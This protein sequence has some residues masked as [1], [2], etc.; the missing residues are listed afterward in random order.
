MSK[1]ILTPGTESVRPTGNGYAP[2]I[3]EGGPKAVTVA[4]DFTT[5]NEI[6]IDFTVIQQL[7]ALSFLQSVFVDNRVNPN[8]LVLTFDQTGQI[9]QI[10]ALSQGIYPVIATVSSKCVATTIAGANVICSLI[11]LNMPMPLTQWGP[12]TV[13]I[14]NV[15]AT[16]TPTAATAADASGVIA[17]GGTSQ[18]LFAA[19]LN[20]KR[21]IIQNPAANND[22]IFIQFGGVA[23]VVGSP[24]IEIS[25]GQEFDT[26]TGPID[27]TR[28]NIISANT[29]DVYTAK[30]FA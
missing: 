14:G 25:V 13:N 7:G 19:N 22:S 10:P 12:T 1:H 20:A 16:F 5:D 17:A 15:T 6:D 26:S 2:K 11:G 18:Q 28:W 21:R 30:E 24:S 3:K 4:L 27:Q 8:A 23:A 9:I 29:N